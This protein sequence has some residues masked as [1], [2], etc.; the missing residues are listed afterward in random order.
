M[1]L[2]YLKKYLP[3]GAKRPVDAAEGGA[4]FC[5]LIFL[6]NQAQG[7]GFFEMSQEAKARGKGLLEIFKKS[8][9][10]RTN[11]ILLKLQFFEIPFGEVAPFLWGRE[12]LSMFPTLPGCAAWAE[13]Q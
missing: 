2:K 4:R 6:K 12:T 9:P 7:K 3:Q 8:Q 11:P 13:P 1:F 10:R 5:F